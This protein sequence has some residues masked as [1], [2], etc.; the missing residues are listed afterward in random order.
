ML[1]FDNPSARMTTELGSKTFEDGFSRL[2]D[3]QEKRI[4]VGADE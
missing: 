3:L 2:F 1:S 4:A